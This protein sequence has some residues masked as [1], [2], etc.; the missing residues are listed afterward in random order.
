[1]NAAVVVART[2]CT[3]LARAS[4][5]QSNAGS[6]RSSIRFAWRPG[7][8]AP[9]I[10]SS[11]CRIA[12]LRLANTTV[13]PGANSFIAA[14][15]VI[16]SPPDGYT[17]FVSTNSPVTTNAAVYKNI[18][19]DPIRDFTP[20]A[21]VTRFPMMRVVGMDSPYKNVSDLI[22]A[23]KQAPGKLNFG[24]S[25]ATYQ[26]NLELFHEMNGIKATHVPY[27]GTSAGLNGGWLLA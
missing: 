12:S 9:T 15:A 8:P 26:A 22:A 6:S 11:L 17:L 3:P 20:I 5:T 13:T 10:V 1:M 19:Y 14:Q 25:T 27:T 21:P 4:D 18:P 2:A 23:A 7:V 24:T 16:A